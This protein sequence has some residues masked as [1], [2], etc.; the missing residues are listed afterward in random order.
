MVGKSEENKHG[1]K[2]IVDA[3]Q[4]PGILAY[5][6]DQVVGWCS[7]A[8]RSE[9]PGLGRSSTLKRI[10]E[11]KNGPLLALRLQKIIKGAVLLRR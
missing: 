6:D 7:I 4:V 1:L 2:S 11:K 9:F 10:D 5:C 3:G 8:P